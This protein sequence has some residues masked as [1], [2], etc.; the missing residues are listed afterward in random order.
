MLVC[1]C[2]GISDKDID[3]ALQEGATSYKALQARLGLGGNCGQC[4]SFAKQMVSD[5]I[6]LVQSANAYH[7]A[8][9]IRL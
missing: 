4:A 3:S 9:E 7:L 5:K 2:N 1:I 8:T 6:A